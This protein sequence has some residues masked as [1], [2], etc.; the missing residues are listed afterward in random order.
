M[1][2]TVKNPIT[3]EDISV[4]IEI[5]TTLLTEPSGL[6]TLHVHGQGSIQLTSE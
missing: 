6:Q 4:D 2:I 5:S 3:N 1:I